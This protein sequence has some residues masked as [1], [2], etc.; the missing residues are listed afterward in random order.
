MF[1]KTLT[2]RMYIY[3]I[4]KKRHRGIRMQFDVYSSCRIVAGYFCFLEVE[5][6]KKQWE[7]PVILILTVVFAGGWYIW[8]RLIQS[9]E[10]P[11]I[12]NPVAFHLKY[13]SQ[14]LFFV[15]AGCAIV[16]G[17]RIRRVRITNPLFW[18]LKLLCFMPVLIFWVAYFLPLGWTVW[19]VWV[20]KN[21]WLFVFPG[22]CFA[23]LEK[24]ENVV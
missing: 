22:I 17:L 11:F 5:G 12:F 16:L 18:C 19:K 20:L 1:H 14:S 10:N 8:S 13:V 6:M 15:A 2:L 7:L 3:N 9:P 23:M 4:S 24:K 21:M